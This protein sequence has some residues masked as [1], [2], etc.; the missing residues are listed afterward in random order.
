MDIREGKW[1]IITNKESFNNV[2]G[3]QLDGGWGKNNQRLLIP[4]V[5]Y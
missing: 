2:F 4:R 5:Y 1:R 3:V